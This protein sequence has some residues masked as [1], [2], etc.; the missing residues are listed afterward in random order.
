MN[1]RDIDVGWKD[2]SGQDDEGVTYIYVSRRPVSR[3]KGSS[4]ILY[5]GQTTG[6]ISRRIQAQ[7]TTSPRRGG[8]DTNSRLSYILSQLGGWRCFY[9][10]GY[11]WPMSPA[12]RQR[13]NRVRNVFTSQKKGARLTFEKYLLVLYAD[14][15]LELPPLN[16]AF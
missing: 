9:V 5:V 15:H 4:D 12:D 14:E 16:N 8:G 6:S 13:F 2:F 1:F 10:D 7:T 3:L 11:L